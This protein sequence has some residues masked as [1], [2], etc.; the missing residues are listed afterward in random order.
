[1]NASSADPLLE[2]PLGWCT[3]QAS[4]LAGLQPCAITVEVTCT[5][6]PAFFQMVGLAQAPVREARVRVTSALAKLGVLLNEHAITVNLAPADLRKTD[7]SLDL[8]IAVAILGS[9]GRIDPRAVSGTLWLG[10]LSLDGSLQPVR[11]VLPQLVGAAERGLRA[12]VLPAANAKEAGLVSRLSVYLTHN[13]EQV[14]ESLSSRT[15]LPCAPKTPFV[16]GVG[17]NSVD[18]S[19]VRGQS[20]ARRAMEIAAA[21]HHNVLLI[22]PPG[23]GK[24]MLARRLPTILPPLSYDEALETTT[25][26]SVAGL[27]DPD[28][29]IVSTRPFRAPHHTITQQGLV[30]GGD[31]PRPGEV[32]LAH[33][34]V[35]FLDEAAEFERRV[36]EA[37]RGPLE[38]GVIRIARARAVAEFPARP[39][40]VAAMNSCPCGYH[41]HPT[42]ACRCTEAQRRRYRM[43]LS[44]PLLDRLDVHVTLAPV[45]VAELAE[46]QV[47]ASTH[48]N[49]IYQRVVRAR[50]HQLARQHSGLSR[51]AT[52]AGLQAHEFEK[53]LKLAAETKAYLSQASRHLTLSARAYTRV[54]RVARTIA[55][56]ED[57]PRVST[58]HVAEALQGRLLDQNW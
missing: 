34:G 24:T 40:V 27:I 48:S 29:G 49:N 7:A 6:G 57:T 36:L 44:G 37:L 21:G 26:H 46:A 28:Q 30:G 47:P 54:L 10:E 56:L 25:V 45:E 35:L 3:V 32:S 53:V 14:T 50:A 19:D 20:A 33:N 12:A 13:I 41:G 2:R 11:G 16:P 5:R 17:A 43:R 52:N 58:R 42:R 23:A 22:G 8:A 38:D 15:P 51:S 39:L 4:T 31:N 55:D 18:F 1:M 9:L